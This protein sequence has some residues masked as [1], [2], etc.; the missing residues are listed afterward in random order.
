MESLY[1]KLKFSSLIEENLIDISDKIDEMI[2]VKYI[3]PSL[4]SGKSILDINKESN[5]DLYKIG[6]IL[7]RYSKYYEKSVY[8]KLIFENAKMLKE[9]YSIDKISNILHFSRIHLKKML[10]SEDASS[11]LETDDPSV[12]ISNFD[13]K[14]KIVKNLLDQHNTITEIEM[15]TGFSRKV[16]YYCIKKMNYDY[17]SVIE[18][19]SQ[20]MWLDLKNILDKGYD[21][22]YIRNMLGLNFDQIR[23]LMQQHN[24]NYKCMP[25]I[26]MNSERLQLA[27]NFQDVERLMNEGKTYREIG[28][29]LHISYQRVQQIAKE[30][31]LTNLHERG[32]RISKLINPEVQERIMELMKKGKKLNQISIELN[33]S[34]GYLKQWFKDNN[35]DYVNLPK[36][37]AADSIFEQ[38]KQLFEEGKTYNETAQILGISSTYIVKL[39]NKYNYRKRK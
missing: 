30:H 21:Y 20:K 27:T 26:H 2:F 12:S 25:R 18:F 3:K 23:K 1:N 4:D 31:G 16:I 17:N 28:R 22:A 19:N 10:I 32:Y 15:I 5:M 37:Y 13:N 35:I 11:I 39:C 34:E 9:N 33:I 36:K 29:I 8:N 38:I 6:F 24:Y 14:C 7:Y